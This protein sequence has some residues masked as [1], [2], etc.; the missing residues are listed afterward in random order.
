MHAR[1]FE[2][3]LEM[4]RKLMLTNQFNN[5]PYRLFLAALSSGISQVDCF[6][7]HTLQKFLLREMRTHA[8][9]VE[10]N[11][12]WATQQRRWS[13]V[14]SGERDVMESGEENGDGSDGSDR[15][16][17]K[18]KGKDVE[19]PMKPT[20]NDPTLPTFYGQSLIM[21]KSYQ[22][23]ICMCLQY[24]TLV[25]TNCFT[26]DY[27]LHAYRFFPND[28]LI[29]ITLAIASLGRAMQRQSD[30]RNYLIV[31][32]M[33]FMEKYRALRGLGNNDPY[34]DEIE[35]NFGRAFH[36]IGASSL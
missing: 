24:S 23:A 14:S 29:C 3:V 16:K 2:V 19:K 13:M 1:K 12:T 32:A 35:Y 36:Q 27:L 25:I 30:N 17:G 33:G 28:P 34:A 11:V 4:F 22:S 18:V 7:N 26:S 8:A 5:E 15:D 20:K 9:A 6:I 31:Q 10:G 21:A